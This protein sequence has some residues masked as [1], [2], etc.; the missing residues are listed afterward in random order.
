[1]PDMALD[2]VAAIRLFE[3][4][5]YDLVLMDCQMPELDGYQAAER[6]RQWESS[7]QQKRTPIIAITAHAMVGDRERCL[8]SGMDAYL[9]KPLSL[10]SLR[11]ALAKWR[12][13][14][15]MRSV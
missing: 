4:N 2:G 14:P 13:R 15:G 10:D 3:Q 11:N 5:I 1:M 6:I 12:V 8:Q 7:R 9:P